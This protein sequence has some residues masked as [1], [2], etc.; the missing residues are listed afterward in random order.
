MHLQCRGRIGKRPGAVSAAA[1]KG[2]TLQVC[3]DCGQI[4]YPRR[5]VCRRCLSAALAERDVLSAG[6]VLAHTMLHIGLEEQAGLTLPQQ[7]VTVVL[8]CGVHLIAVSH[9]VLAVDDRVNVNM[10]DGRLWAALEG[11]NKGETI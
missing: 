6:V 4:Q 8:D 5:E 2:L 11:N 3:Q 1:A 7:I 9:N 10:R